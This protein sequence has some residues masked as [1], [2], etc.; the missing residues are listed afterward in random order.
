MRSAASQ[1][2]DYSSTSSTATVNA[3]INI[4]V[5]AGGMSLEMASAMVKRGVEEGISDMINAARSLVPS[6]EA[7]RL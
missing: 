7:R 6:P 5:D 1:H 3:P 2:N 4:K